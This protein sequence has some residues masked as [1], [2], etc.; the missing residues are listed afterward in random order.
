MEFVMD[1]TR[2]WHSVVGLVLMIPAMPGMIL[3]RTLDGGNQK[4][5]LG[6]QEPY[7]HVRP[8]HI[9]KSNSPIESRLS[10]MMTRGVRRL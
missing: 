6:E 8:V 4:A 2:L 5:L 3:G 10:S 7:K 9:A 1:F